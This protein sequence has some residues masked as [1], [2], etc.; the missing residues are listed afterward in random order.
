MPESSEPSVPPVDPL[1]LLRPPPRRT[2]HPV[3]RVGVSGFPGG[4]TRELCAGCGA[5][6]QRWFEM[7]DA[8]YDVEFVW[9]QDAFD[10]A[11]TRQAA[12][13]L[14]EAGCLAVVGH[15]SSS[16]SLVA[17][18][19]YY[20]ARI[21]F[22]A[23]GS[24]HPRLTENG[25]WNVLR[26]CGRD[27][28]LADTL[29]GVVAGSPWRKAAIIWQ[30][31]TYGQTLAALLQEALR[32]RGRDV[33]ASLPWRAVPAETATLT[34][35]DM[36]LFAGT[37]ETSVQLLEQLRAIGYTGALVLG[38]D[39]YIAELPL[40]AAA[41]LTDQTY[42]VS[43]AVDRT[44]PEYQPF[45]RHYTER[46]GLEPGAYSAPAYLAMSLLLQ[47]LDV[48]RDDGPAAFVDKAR[49]IAAASTTLLGPVHF[50]RQGDLAPFPWDV[51]RIEEGRF[52][53]AALTERN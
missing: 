44:H 32:K 1:A 6:V 42:I 24:T 16:A 34:E 51:Y 8:R 39:A 28:E 2:D 36:L 7:S 19:L 45:Y 31:I 5:A 23:P 53:S 37:F 21:P 26:V 30:E 25:F 38:D 9:E 35:S 10:P 43:T 46:A 29:A 49:A 15:L 22:L 12:R 33:A 20:Q 50:T 48:L 13:R 11:T 27:D 40:R 52:V 4:H 41:T 47:A 18:E 3:V 17:S 14:I